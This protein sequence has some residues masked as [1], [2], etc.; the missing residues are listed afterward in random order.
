MHVYGCVAWQQISYISVSLFG[1][2]RIEN[3]FPSVVTC[4]R[5]YNA[6]AWQTR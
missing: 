3:S 4:I 1:A 6:V 2:N 5:V